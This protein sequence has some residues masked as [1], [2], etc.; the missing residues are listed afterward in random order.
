[1]MR[2]IGVFSMAKAKIRK[3]SLKRNEEDLEKLFAILDFIC[4]K[5]TRLKRLK[6]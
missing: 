5:N 1:M 4:D 3:L 6:R 2:R